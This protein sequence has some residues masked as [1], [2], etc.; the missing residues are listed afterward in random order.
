MFYTVS[1]KIMIG[2]ITPT[3]PP[4]TYTAIPHSG[5]TPTMQVYSHNVIFYVYLLPQCTSCKLIPTD[6]E[7]H[8]HTLDY[9][10]FV[11]F[12]FSFSFL[13]LFLYLVQLPVQKKADIRCRNMNSR[14]ATVF[15][16]HL[17]QAYCICSHHKDFSRQF[18]FPCTTR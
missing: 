11:F 7:V 6:L 10:L 1:F 3:T 5:G 9:L 8:N 15:L 4:D 16:F 18:P 17:P 13:Y 12:C 14:R 2:Y